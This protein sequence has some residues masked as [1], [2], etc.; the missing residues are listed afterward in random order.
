MSGNT[1]GVVFRVTTWGES[2]G[3]AVGAV[4]DGCPPGIALAAKAI[5]QELD[6]RTPGSDALASR[7]GRKTG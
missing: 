5:Q 6:R 4:V 7:A 3:E 2:H 1:T